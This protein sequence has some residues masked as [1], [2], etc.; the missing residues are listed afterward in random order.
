MPVLHCT[1]GI[2]PA[3]YMTSAKEP[4]STAENAEQLLASL[5]GVISA[6]V[7]ADAAGALVEI[8]VLADSE[9]HPKQ[10][11]RNVESALTAGLGLTIDRRI[12]SVAQIQSDVDTNGHRSPSGKPE[13]LAIR[14]EMNLDDGDP[15]PAVEA[16]TAG[17]R[18]EFVRYESRRQ[19]DRCS[20]TVILRSGGGAGAR[21][22]SA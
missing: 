4:L 14:P 22:L 1:N 16:E 19:S 11:V 17:P 9:H 8:H 13:M 2:A 7:V 10:V 15:A 21:S 20:C 3:A 5:A 18:L 6:H 12:V